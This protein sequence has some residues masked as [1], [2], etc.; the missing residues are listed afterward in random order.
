MVRTALVV[1]CAAACVAG[2]APRHTTGGGPAESAPARV[3]P[4]TFRVDSVHSTIIYRVRHF[5]VANFY[6]RIQAPAGDFRID[7]DD[8]AGSF[9]NITIDIKRMDAGNDQ[10]N[11][12]LLS[13]DFF[14]VREYPTA[15]FKSTSVR[16]VAGGTYEADGDFTMHGVTKPLTVTVEQFTTADVP[17]FGHRGGFETT[18]TVKR[19]DYGMD[20]FVKEGTL[21]DEVRIT[22]AIEGYVDPEADDN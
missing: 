10:R 16:K 18:F 3:D 12:F 2:L 20:L 22:A 6:G 17:R 8:L 14:N 13:P 19:S 11:G 4:S 9:V 15:T 1:V 21:G 7:D 5:G